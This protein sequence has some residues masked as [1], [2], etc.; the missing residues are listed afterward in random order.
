MNKAAGA[1]LILAAAV[2]S[3][4]FYLQKRRLGIELLLE[5]SRDM[6]HIA[7][8]IRWKKQPIPEILDA[9]SAQPYSGEYYKR[10]L[11]MMQSNIP[12]HT[13]WNLVFSQVQP[14]SVASV[15]CGISLSGDETAVL[16]SLGC[17]SESLREMHLSQKAVQREKTKICI[18]SVLSAAG[19]LII[20]LI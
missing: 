18:A 11:D 3:L 15:M 4:A 6:D 8:A 7:A 1:V 12:L 19:M 2:I 20:L 16:G 10:I 5:L 14:K 13:A 9:F 17:A